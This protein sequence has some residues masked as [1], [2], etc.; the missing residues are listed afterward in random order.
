MRFSNLVA[1]TKYP[2]FSSLMPEFSVPRF[3]QI[4]LPSYQKLS[5]NRRFQEFPHA[6]FIQSH[7]RHNP[8]YSHIRQRSVTTI[9]HI[10][11]LPP[12]LHRKLFH[13]RLSCNSLLMHVST[14]VVNRRAEILIPIH[15]VCTCLP[16]LFSRKLEIHPYHKHMQRQP[17]VVCRKPRTPQQLLSRNA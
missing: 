1:L 14:S 3:W 8:S 10:F 11:W 13:P 4:V 15:I 12:V 5:K 7:H 6:R 2:G 17:F 16:P 9:V